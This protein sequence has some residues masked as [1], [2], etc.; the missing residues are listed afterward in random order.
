M[1]TKPPCLPHLGEPQGGPVEPHAQGRRGGN[2]ARAT[3]F[4]KLP[5]SHTVGVPPGATRTRHTG[6]HG[7][8]APGAASTQ[9]SLHSLSCLNKEGAELVFCFFLF[10]FGL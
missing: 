8:A 3:C 2:V 6:P 7:N 10:L 1:R 5:P 9:T 4:S